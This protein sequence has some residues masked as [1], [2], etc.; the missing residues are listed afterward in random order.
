MQ[1]Y[2]LDYE[3]SKTIYEQC[4]HLIAPKECYNN[5]FHV[6]TQY[7]HK[8][9]SGDWKIDYGYVSSVRNLYCRHCFILCEDKVID[10]TLVITNNSEDNLYFVFKTFEN[11]N[12]YLAALDKEDNLPA[13]MWTL[14]KE[15]RCA[16]QW[17]LENN[18]I[19]I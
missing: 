1:K 6:L 12:D 18:I 16:Q 8:F 2:L 13:L 5:I 19:C 7:P 11:I 10:P 4:K 14:R 17:A 3:L 9:Q 15:D